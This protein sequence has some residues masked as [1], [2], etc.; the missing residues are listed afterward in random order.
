MNNSKRLKHLLGLAALVAMGA[1]VTAEAQIVTSTPTAPTGEPA[2]Y[3][4]NGYLE[5]DANYSHLDNGFPS[6]NGGT[7]QGAIQSDP[8]NI[9]Y[10]SVNNEEEFNVRGTQVS[11]GNIHYFSPKVFTNINVGTGT[12]AFFMPRAHVEGAISRR[13]LPGN[14]LVGTLDVGYNN[15]HLGIEDRWTQISG[16]Y[17]VPNK[18]LN[19][20]AGVRFNRSSPG[21]VDSQQQYVAATYG[22]YKKQFLTVRY[23]WGTEGY[24]LETPDVAVLEKFNSNYV[25]VTWRKWVSHNNGFTATIERYHNPFFTRNGVLLGVFHDFGT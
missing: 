12:N 20:E 19:F 8:K 11:A 24:Q 3:Q 25:G 4:K 10:G 9:W 17:F 18:P 13:F 5:F 15:N 6:W 1:A 23:N 14:N 2:P 7:I 16:Q 22:Q 21:S